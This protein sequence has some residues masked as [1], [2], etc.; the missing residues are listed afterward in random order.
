MTERPQ[1][2]VQTASRSPR[3]S[4]GRFCASVNRPRSRLRM[5]V[6]LGEDPRRRD[7]RS[8][9]SFATFL[10]EAF[11]IPSGSM[12]RTLLVGDFLLVNKLVY[13]AE[14]PFTGKHLPA[15]REPAARRRHRV[16]VAEGSVEELREAARRACRA[17]RSRCATA[18]SSA[19]G[20]VAQRAVRRRTRDPETDPSGEEFR[21]QTKSPREDAPRPR[22]A[23]HPSRNNW[24]PLVV[25]ERQYFVLGDNRDNSLDSR[26]WGFVPDS[27]VRGRPHGGV[28]QLTRRIRSHRLRVADPRPMDAARRARPLT[29]TDPTAVVR[30]SRRDHRRERGAPQEPLPYGHHSARQE[31]VVRG[32]LAR[33]VPPRHQHLSADHARRR[34]RASRSAFAQS[35]QEALD[36]LV[37]SNLRFVVSVA[38]KYQNQGVSLSDLI[39]EGNLG[40][41]RAAHKFDE[42]KGIKFISYAVWWIRQAILQALAEQSRIVRV[43]LNRAGTLHRIG[44]RANTLLQELGREATHAEI[45]DGMDITEE[46]VAKTMSISQT[47]LSLDAPLTPGEDN[48]LLDYL[49]DNL[50]PTPDEQTFEKAL[51]ESIEEALAQPEGARGEDPAPLLRARRRGAD[52][53]R[54]DRRRCSASRASGCGRSRRRRFRGYA[55]CRGRA[56]SSPTSDRPRARRIENGAAFGLAPFLLLDV[57]DAAFVAN[58][59]SPTRM[60]TI[61]LVRSSPSPS[62]ARARSPRR[63]SWL[64]RSRR[65]PST[66]RITRAITRGTRTDTG[67]PGPRYWQQWASYRLWRGSTR[68]RHSSPGEGTVRYHNRSPDT[69][70]RVAVQLLQNLFASNSPKN[71]NVPVTGGLR[72]ERVTVEG[73]EL[74]RGGDGGYDVQATIGWIPLS[75]PLAP[76][77]SVELGFMWAFRVPPGSAP[78]MGQDGEVFFIAQWYP[79]R[80]RLRRRQRVADRSLPWQRRV[81]LRLRATTTSR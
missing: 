75:R 32:R 31:V 13:G 65:F 52:D 7:R 72:L 54:A 60:R 3:S 8:S 1:H 42:T 44:K 41:I 51:T 39:N 35:D 74:A 73:R 70:R 43:P 63:P 56:R 30:I 4:A 11:K 17:T 48:K 25:P 20:R 55:T 5:F 27:L 64:A 61:S 38:K 37:R 57:A 80:R 76:G 18:I 47:H 53:A 19:N 36:K 46:E 14:V 2:H 12:E 6:G 67:P 50:N 69:L 28:L 40:L 49:P 21:W 58:A 78:R 22:A 26:Y 66:R 9:C 62:H 68:A 71:E 59:H 29:L 77:D 10:V 23:Y 15:M 24:G 81:L 79:D 16:P 45:A 34:G 33:P